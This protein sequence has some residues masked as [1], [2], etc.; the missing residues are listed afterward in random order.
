MFRSLNN[1]NFSNP[2]SNNYGQFNQYN[3]LFQK[4]PNSPLQ[5]INPEYSNRFL[6][7]RRP[8][9]N[10]PG[11]NKQILSPFNFNLNSL[12]ALF[13]Q[14]FKVSPTPFPIPKP[15]P[16][17]TPIP[18]PVPTPTP[19]PVPVPTPIPVPVP[20]PTPVPVPV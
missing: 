8:D 6:N 13:S 16:V 9:I 19:V 2:R 5:N 4:R 17:P 10:Y 12:I 18:V 15:V 14:Y 3:Q 1:F 11:P 20:T 7:Q